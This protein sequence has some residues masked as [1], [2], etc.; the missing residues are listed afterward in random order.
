VL[1]VS[2]LLECLP[3]RDAGAHVNVLLLQTVLTSANHL[4]AAVIV[5]EYHRSV[6]E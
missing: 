1:D 5:L 6:L 2:K 3:P 4:N